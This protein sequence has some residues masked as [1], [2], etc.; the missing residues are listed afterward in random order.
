M[1]VDAPPDTQDPLGLCDELVDG[2]YRVRSIVARGGFGVVYRAQHISLDSWVALK[3]LKPGERARRQ[4][5]QFLMEAKT[6]A[7]LR[8]A[9]IVSVFDAGLIFDE[10]SDAHLPWIALEWIAGRT[11]RE[12]IADRAATRVPFDV[13]SIQQVVCPVV[14]AL[15]AAHAAGIAHRDI[16]PSNIMLAETE[17]ELGDPRVL[18]FGI[19]KLMAGDEAPGSGQTATRGGRSPF[20]LA[21]AAPEQLSGARTG[22]WTDVHAVGLLLTE[23]LTG[24]APYPQTDATETYRAAFD[25]VRPTPGSFGID[26]GPLEAVIERCLRLVPD[27]R[28]ADAAELHAAL[29]TALGA[30]PKIVRPTPRSPAPP[31]PVRQI[32]TGGTHTVTTPPSAVRSAGSRW[33]YVALA[34]VVGI[35]SAVS[36]VA[37]T[38]S[39][40]ATPTTAV[41][42]DAVPSLAPAV[43]HES[44]QPAEPHPEAQVEPSMSPAAPSTQLAVSSASA[45]GST[46]RRARRRA[47]SSAAPPSS[48]PPSPSPASSATAPPTARPVP[49]PLVTSSA[50]PPYE[51]D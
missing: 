29:Q 23:L 12:A 26:A 44:T 49:R 22:P 8:H 38:R 43:Q 47:V 51:L 36:W 27:E 40:E 3:V 33:T 10:Q 31:A 5:D 19:A 16:K 24:R 25:A 41:S 6:L 50:G 46:A 13:Q 17:R 48:P 15:S 18:D 34:S 20:S 42:P 2:K 28:Y 35:G 9:H 45:R 39:P 32:A 11:L 30:Q 37:L 14:E 4:V 7:R 21:Y 1:S